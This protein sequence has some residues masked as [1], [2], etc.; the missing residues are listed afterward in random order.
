MIDFGTVP[1]NVQRLALGCFFQHIGPAE[2]TE[3]SPPNA[4]SFAEN[5]GIPFR[6]YIVAVEWLGNYHAKY[7]EALRHYAR[8][9]YG[10]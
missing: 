3:L 7:V 1:H 4:L 2:L 10:R 9:L 8:A 6:E 5:L